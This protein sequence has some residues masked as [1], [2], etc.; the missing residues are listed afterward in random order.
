MNLKFG[1]ASTEKNMRIRKK[2]ILTW[3]VGLNALCFLVIGCFFECDASSTKKEKETV[4][5][6]F[7]FESEAAVEPDSYA[8]RDTI[9]LD[10]A[11]KVKNKCLFWSNDK[12]PKSWVGLPVNLSDI[13]VYSALSFRMKAEAAL[14]GGEVCVGFYKAD[15]N[16]LMAHVEVMSEEWTSYQVPLGFMVGSVTFTPEEITQ[17]R[18][19]LG[20]HPAC[21]VWIDDVALVRGKEGARSWRASRKAKVCL[22]DPSM[23]LA[24][25]AA[26]S[27]VSVEGKGKNLYVEWDIS[28]VRNWTNLAITALPEDIRSF[29]ALKMSIKA[30][31]PVGKEVVEARFFHTDDVY[32]WASMP[33]LTTKWRTVEIPLAYFTPVESPDPEHLEG[34]KL[35]CWKQEPLT[36]RIKNLELVKGKRGNRSWEPTEKD[37][38]TRIFGEDGIKKALTFETRHFRVLA[39][40]RTVKG[41]FMKCMEGHHDFIQDILLLPELEEKVVAY[42]FRNRDDYKNFCVRSEGYTPQQ[43]EW[44]HGHCTRNYF[45][46]YYRQPDTASI[47]YVL[48]Q[49]MVGR[50]FGDYGGSWIR[51]GFAEYAEYMY[52]ERDV[53]KEF[54][55]VLKQRQFTPL[56]EFLKMKSLLFTGENRKT[57]HGVSHYKQAAAFFAFMLKGPFAE[58]FVDAVTPILSRPMSSK[59]Q[60]KCLEEV[61][62]MSLEEIENEWVKWGKKLDRG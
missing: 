29:S 57:K 9:R 10:R 15:G 16:N 62:G 55:V 45:A 38:L 28:E 46:T 11:S 59:K 8:S 24:F 3:F 41:K 13:K 48:T 42:I 7:S 52:R 30:D 31:R 4:E 6:L 26:N 53:A 39:N 37:M 56:R 32:F 25:D 21:D 2:P 14:V 19:A 12:G 17:I 40:T 27:R 47:V 58:K 60:I 54:A 22:D 5:M 20:D 36:I 23:N 1:S 61:Y 34:L 50:T 35:L 18:W 51:V 44:V 33:E 43:A 49:A